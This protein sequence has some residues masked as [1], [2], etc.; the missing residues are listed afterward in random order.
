MVLISTSM[1]MVHILLGMQR[2][3]EAL[4]YAALCFVAEILGLVTMQTAI[5]K[6]GWV[7]LIVFLVSVV[8]AISTVAMTLYVWRQ[9]I[10]GEYMGF[11]LLC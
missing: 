8:M 3:D 2:I 11:R 9:I 6:S 4:K 7:S 5:R 10:N 1:S